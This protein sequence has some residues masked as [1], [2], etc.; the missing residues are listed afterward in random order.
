MNWL[1]VVAAAFG[2]ISVWLSTREHIGSWPTALVN[3]ALYFVVLQRANLYA[4][5]WLQVFYFALSLY[6]WYAWKFG[7]DAHAG[8]QI[9]RTPVRT[10]WL[11]LALVAVATL[12]IEWS[13]SRFTD[14]STQ[15]LDASTTAVSLAA[16]WMLTRKL[17][18]TWGVWTLV[19]VVYIGLYASE[20][21]WATTVLY[22]AFLALAIHGW[23]S[24]GAL[25]R[26]REQA[27]A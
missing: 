3:T 22:V 7:G 26:A 8:V 15:W 13:L 2:V 18:E 6:G 20:Q 27:A 1:E 9:S 23:R 24:W 17:R 25:L 4:N 12:V 14:S 21:M 11:L 16:Q 19:N 5:A 10:A